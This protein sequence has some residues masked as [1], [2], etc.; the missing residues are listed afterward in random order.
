MLPS[1]LSFDAATRTFSGTPTAAETVSVKVTASDA[2]DSVSDT[3]DIVVSAATVVLTGQLF[4]DN[5]GEVVSSDLVVNGTISQS[6]T[7]GPNT[8]GYI[9]TS[10]SVVANSAASGDTF[11][12]V[13]H[14]ADTN[15]R[16]VALHASMIAPSNFPAGESTITFSA[17]PNTMLEADTPYAIV[18][19]QVGST[20][21]FLRGTN[22]DA[23]NAGTSGWS[24]DDANHFYSFRSMAWRRSASAAV[25]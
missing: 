1:W 15:G 9:L 2:S 7:T 13:V 21:W 18:L 24:I 11:S 3:F 8:G 14:T 19:G 23:D 6:F 16:P 12:L 4:V 10:I 22:S 5:T 20:G 25:Q 17:P